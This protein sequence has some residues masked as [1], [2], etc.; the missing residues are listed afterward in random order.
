MGVRLRVLSG[1]APVEVT[2]LSA[3]VSSSSLLRAAVSLQPHPRRASVTITPLGECVRLLLSP[4]VASSATGMVIGAMVFAKLQPSRLSAAVRAQLLS[5]GTR[6]KGSI[7]VAGRRRIVMQSWAN[8][9]GLPA[10]LNG[11]FSRWSRRLWR[12]RRCKPEL[13]S[14]GTTSPSEFIWQVRRLQS[15]A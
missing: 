11:C 7:S 14:S 10:R 9:R 8:R 3:P 6:V 13:W 1:Q 15:L 4:A 2:A 5:L 12:R